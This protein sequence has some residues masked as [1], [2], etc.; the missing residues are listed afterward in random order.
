MLRACFPI[1]AYFVTEKLTDDIIGCVELSAFCLKCL[2]ETAYHFTS[3]K[4]LFSALYL[5]VKY[6]ENVILPIFCLLQ[7][8]F[9]NYFVNGFLV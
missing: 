2:L 3:Y 4:L 6:S 5:H 9:Y 7:Y 8:S 1:N